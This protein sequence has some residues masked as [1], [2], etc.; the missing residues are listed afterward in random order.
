LAKTNTRYLQNLAYCR[1]KNLTVGY[2]LPA[3]LTKKAF[4]DRVRF[5]FSGDNLATWTKL[6][7]DYIDPEQFASDGDARVYPFAKTFSFGVDVTF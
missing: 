1:L 5:Y 3:S 2:T 4:I 7:S 6:R